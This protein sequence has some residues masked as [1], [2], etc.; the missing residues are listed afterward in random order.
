MKVNTTLFLYGKAWSIYEN[1]IDFYKQYKKHKNCLYILF[2]SNGYVKIGKTQNFFQ[3]FKSLLQ[4]AR[5]YHNDDIIKIFVS[6]SHPEYHLNEKILHNLLSKFQVYSFSG[7]KSELFDIS[8]KDIINCGQNSNILESKCNKIN[9]INL[10][11]NID[12]IYTKERIINVIDFLKDI[13]ANIEHN[14]E[15]FENNNFNPHEIK[16][17]YRSV[18]LDGRMVL[19]E[20]YDKI[21]K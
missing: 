10:T 5:L 13:K 20:K 3:R 15:Y 14:I 12:S 6:E 16:S 4:N 17:I 7:N 9:D 21:N 2:Y 8:E 19:F 1:N 18:M 11:K